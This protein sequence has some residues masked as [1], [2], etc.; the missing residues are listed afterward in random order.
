MALNSP[1]DLFL[2]ELSAMY[3]A[4]QKIAGMLSEAAGQV[5]DENLTQMMRKHE[6]ETRQQITNLEQCFQQ[7]GA[8]PQQVTCAA[9]DGMRTDYQQVMSMQPSPE[10]LNMFAIGAAMKVEKYESASYK[11]LVDK[12]MLMGENQCAQLLQTNLLQEEETAGKLERLSHDM[13]QRVMTSV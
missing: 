6:Q 10:I 11:G 4:E 13:S 7:L 12:A 3:D 9:I 1:K 5:P 8:Q 2:L